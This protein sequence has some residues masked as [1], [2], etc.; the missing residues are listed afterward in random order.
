MAEENEKGEK[1]NTD[2]IY[3]AVL[4]VLAIVT[5][6]FFKQ[7][8]LWA[9]I[10][11]FLGLIIAVFSGKVE[12]RS[13]ALNV[14]IFAIIFGAISYLSM[15]AYAE[16]SKLQ[17]EMNLPT[18]PQMIQE[19][20]KPFVCLFNY[21]EC[22]KQYSQS[23]SYDSS[24][25]QSGS[26]TYM[27]VNFPYN[28]VRLNQS[29]EVRGE[30]T[31][32]NQL[33]DSM[34]ISA[35]CFINNIS[36]KVNPSVI[37]VPKSS[38]EQYSVLTCSSDQYAKGDLSLKLSSRY[39]A[40]TVLPIT[41]GSTGNIGKKISEMQYDSPYKLSVSLSYSQPLR[42]GN[43]VMYVVLEKQQSSILTNL[44]L[45]K[46]LTISEKARISCDKMQ[47]L[48]L[49]NLDRQ[50]LEQFSIPSKETFIWQCSLDVENALN[51]PEEAYIQAEAIYT[52][53][54]EYKTSLQV[55]K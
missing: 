21:D 7:A 2:L 20:K 38:T 49:S 28:F 6:I 54:S 55:V 17:K 11:A 39:K 41:I 37:D 5:L 19:A 30:L 10:G 1:R 31:I 8:I 3:V 23:Y 52:A 34:H 26:K 42:N 43:Y 15:P 24:T 50:A 29:V 53:E 16:I 13:I 40:E 22:Q 27:N 44:E 4:V 48:Q 47:T 33:F 46:V 35:N 51:T 36:V 9:G 32:M 12:L 25:V 14:A 18:F 45:L